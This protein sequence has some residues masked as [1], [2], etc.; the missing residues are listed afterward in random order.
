MRRV[1]AGTARRGFWEMPRRRLTDWTG[2][3]RAKGKPQRD[4]NKEIKDYS[5]A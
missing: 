3:T 5:H 1:D 2:P 4:K